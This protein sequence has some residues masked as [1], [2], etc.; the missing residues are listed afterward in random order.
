MLTLLVH[1]LTFQAPA[2]YLTDDER[3]CLSV[4]TVATHCVDGVHA[5]M[6]DDNQAFR[7]CYTHGCRYPLDAGE[8]KLGP[9]A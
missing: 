6:R 8:A 3:R 7:P 2:C 5:V 4:P 1:L 9:G